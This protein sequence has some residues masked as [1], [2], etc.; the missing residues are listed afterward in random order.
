M[1]GRDGSDPVFLQARELRGR[2]S[3][4]SPAR[5][6]YVHQ[7]RDWQF[8]PDVET[9]PPG[10]LRAP[11]PVM[12]D[13][14][15]ASPEVRTSGSWPST[16]RGAARLSAL[17]SGGGEARRSVPSRRPGVTLPLGRGSE[18]YWRVCEDRI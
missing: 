5:D 15:R 13:R 10:G 9:M 8:S 17:R 18:V 1:L 12:P 2:C 4:V 16:Q 7:L 11:A 3:A 6:F 14:L